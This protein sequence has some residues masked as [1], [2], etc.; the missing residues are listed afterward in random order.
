M[1]IGEASVSEAWRNTL[2]I[3]GGGGSKSRA[4]ANQDTAA[5]TTGA[6]KK[7]MPRF[8][9]PETTVDESNPTFR[10]D[11]DRSAHRFDVSARWCRKELIEGQRRNANGRVTGVSPAQFSEHSGKP[12]P[13]G[14]VNSLVQRGECQ[15]LP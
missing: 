4:S 9:T 2:A 1:T 3:D 10:A 11:S 13:F 7:L 6:E 5:M 12:T 15:R 8:D 14:L